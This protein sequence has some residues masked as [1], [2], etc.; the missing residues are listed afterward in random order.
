MAKTLMCDRCKKIKSEE[1]FRKEYYYSFDEGG[2]LSEVK[3]VFLDPCREVLD[4]CSECANEI[5]TKF[6]EKIRG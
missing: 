6:G 5:V 2:K 3:V 1:E 4:I